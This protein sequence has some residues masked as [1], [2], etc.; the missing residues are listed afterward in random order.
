[1]K[2]VRVRQFGEPEVLCLEEVPDLEPAAGQVLIKLEAAGINPVEAY[3]RAG[4]YGPR[5]TLPYTPGTDGAG[6]VEAVGPGVVGVVAGD[7]VYT[8][9][10]ITGTYA[11]KALVAE[12]Q[13]HPLPERVGFAQGAAIGIPYATAYRALIQRAKAEPGE[14]VL[15]HG[16]SGGVGLAAVQLSVA[17]GI[18]VIGTAGSE[19][20]RRLVL[21]QGAEHVLDHGK[22][23]YLRELISLTAGRGPEVILE[24]LANVNLGHDLEVLAPRGRVVV[25]GS[26]GPVEISPRDL[27]N[28][29]GSLLA[30][31][32]PNATPA[33]RARADAAIHAGL[34]NGTLRP[35]V[36]EE[37]ALGQAAQAHR[38]LF[39][40]KAA[41]KIVLAPGR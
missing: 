1:M 35:V 32:L 30:M 15:V 20:G 36:R 4:L 13:I 29:E 34:E 11:E 41:G 18:R 9:S 12:E 27:M 6:V 8:S 17:R 24:M 38:W 5:P 19:E 22:E 25:I 31:R 10:S 40:S 39:E 3:V 37:L 28:R 23:G 16:A 14:V 2:A 33:E 7:R 26:R 21:A